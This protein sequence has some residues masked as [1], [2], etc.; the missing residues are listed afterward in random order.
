M[1]IIRHNIDVLDRSVVGW[2]EA[3]DGGSRVTVRDLPLRDHIDVP[4]REQLIVELYSQVTHLQRPQTA[5]QTARNIPHAHHPA[6][7]RRSARRG[8]RATAS[9]SPSVRS[10][11]AS[12]TRS[13]TPCAAPCC[14][15]S[16]A[17]PSPGAL[18][19][20]PPRVRHHRRRRRGRHRHHPEPEGHRAHVRAPTS[21]SSIRLDVRGPADVAAGDIKLPPE[22]EIL[23]R[24]APHRHAQRQGP[25]G[26]RPHRRAGPGLPVARTG[27]RRPARSASSRSTPSSRRSGA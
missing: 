9:S 3:G 26:R 7:H 4:V 2:L 20:R 17:Q 12:A 14:R 19:R 6:S 22:I 23:N 13:A 5:H 16:R 8:R 24:D 27:S 15:R 10:S 11:P 1:I 18:R 25:P 21:R